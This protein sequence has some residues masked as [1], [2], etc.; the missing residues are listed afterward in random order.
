MS[1]RAPM[2]P[3][4]APL[5][6][7]CHRLC[8]CLRDWIPSLR[9]WNHYNTL[10]YGIT[11]EKWKLIVMVV[12]PHFDG[13]VVDVVRSVIGTS[14]ERW[15]RRGLGFGFQ[16]GIFWFGLF[17]LRLGILEGVWERSLE[18]ETFFF[19]FL[20]D[21]GFQKGFGRKQFRIARERSAKIN[22]DD[23]LPQNRLQTPGNCCL[24]LSTWGNFCE[25]PPL[26]T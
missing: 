4:T 5:Q 13:R 15:D 11:N 25:P 16:S 21:S 22:G 1:P 18:W 24:V 26:V 19:L 8:H 14:C 9:M 7:Q 12:Q 17:L 6:S 20:K 2:A 3:H 23:K 10:K